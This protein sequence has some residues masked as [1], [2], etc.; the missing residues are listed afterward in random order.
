MAVYSN[1]FVEVVM[2]SDGRAYPNEKVACHHHHQQ[3]D[4][5]QVAVTRVTIAQYESIIALYSRRRREETEYPAWL[6]FGGVPGKFGQS[7][8]CLAGF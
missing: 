8:A 1:R 7:R 4:I 6:T 3:H 5:T 2:D